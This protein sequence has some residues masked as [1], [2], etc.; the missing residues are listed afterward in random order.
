MNPANNPRIIVALDYA[1]TADAEAFIARV[2]PER[3]R[4]KIGL[5]LYT[6]AGPTF[7]RDVVARGFGVFLDLK[8]HDIP[9]TVERACRQA[10]A[11]GAEL[12][13]VHCLGG[14]AMLEAAR[15]GVGESGA[16]RRP[17]VLGVTLLTSMGA[18]D[19]AAIGLAGDAATCSPALAELARAAGLDGI[20]CAPTEARAL[21][22][23][24]GPDFL[25]VTP[26]IRPAGA[27]AG[28]QQRIATP[29]DAIAAGADLLVIG[30][31]I[32]QAPDPMA[33]LG[34]V[35]RELAHPGI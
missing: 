17:R 34:A 1:S 12:L 32:T 21:R 4:L 18:H 26:G 6:A 23:R 20:I 19:L 9:N 25:L 28:D 7:V 22:A 31:P 16:P 8:F 15:R 10:A 3:C 30:R 11:L 24:F 27:A 29:R 13:S 35:E 14:P 5:E 33:A 2:S